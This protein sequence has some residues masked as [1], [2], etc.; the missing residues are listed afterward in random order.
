MLN[1]AMSDS[2]NRIFLMGLNNMIA[3]SSPAS[4]FNI[5]YVGFFHVLCCEDGDLVQSSDIAKRRKP[6]LE[7]DSSAKNNNLQGRA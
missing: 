7:Y 4:W 6:K 3:D 5:Q 2:K 1:T